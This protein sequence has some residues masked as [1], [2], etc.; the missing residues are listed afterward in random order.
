MRLRPTVR[1]KLTLTYGGL[2]LLAG[3]V[4]LALN[5]G[6]VRRSLTAQRFITEAPVPAAVEVAPGVLVPAPAL[7]LPLSEEGLPAADVLN[8]VGGA[9]RDR[10]LNTL[11][12]QSGLALALMSVGSLG[13]GWVVAGRTLRPLH[14][15]TE[16][17]K[18][19]SQ[20]NLHERIN[21][22]GPQDELK[23]LADTFDAMLFRLDRAFES[24]RRFVA[25]ASHELRTPLA[26]M[27]AEIDVALADPDTPAEELRR[28]AEVVREAVDRS[29]RLIGGLLILARSERD[30]GV[31]EAVDLGSLAAEAL[32]RSERRI[33]ELELTVESRVPSATALGNRALLERMVENLV[34]NAVLHNHPGGW[35]RVQTGVSGGHASLVVSNSGKRIAPSEVPALF[36]PFRRLDGERTESRRGLGLGLSIVRATAEASGGEVTAQPRAEGGLEVRVLLPAAASSGGG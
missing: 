26:I 10:A 27:R 19:L 22:R 6:L 34:E 28:M 16:K 4:L 32:T 17:A 21:L 3:T 36:E 29:E 18:L 23:E 15:I 8:E 11:L 35:V 9:V 14:K 1:L 12:A 20:E 24:Q 25:N 2:F 5:Y 7:R 13:L 33:Q 30:R 31:S